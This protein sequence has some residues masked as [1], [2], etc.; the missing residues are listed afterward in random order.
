MASY[1]SELVL[2][3]SSLRSGVSNHLSSFSIPLPLIFKKQRTPLIKKIQGLQAP[4]G[5]TSGRNNA[6]IPRDL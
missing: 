5:A 4:H 3:S 6:T 1:G 2:D